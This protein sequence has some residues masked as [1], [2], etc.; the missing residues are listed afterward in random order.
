MDFQRMSKKANAGR[1]ERGYLNVTTE[2]LTNWT[3]LRREKTPET[4]FERC[5]KYTRPCRIFKRQSEFRRKLRA[6]ARKNLT[7]FRFRA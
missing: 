1:F 4:N 3:L 2:N 5:P 6:R 7:S